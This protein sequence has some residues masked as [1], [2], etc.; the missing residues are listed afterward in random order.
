MPQRALAGAIMSVK[1]GAIT[2]AI[3]AHPENR[4][5]EV[6]RAPETR[7][8]RLTSQTPLNVVCAAYLAHCRTRTTHSSLAPLSAK[9][10]RTYTYSLAPMGWLG[11]VP[12][13]ELRTSQVLERVDELMQ[14]DPGTAGSKPA[15]FA[16]TL[17]ALLAW[18]RARDLCI[19][20]A[21]AQLR[22]EYRPTPRLP[23]TLGQVQRI[24]EEI[25]TYSAVRPSSR[26]LKRDPLYPIAR[27]GVADALRLLILTGARRAEIC[28]ARAEW[29]QLDENQLLVPYAKGHPRV[30]AFGPAA[31]SIF[32]ARLEL[33]QGVTPYLF[34]SMTDANRPLDGTRVLELFHEVCKRVGLYES[35]PTTH[36]RKKYCVHTFRNSLAT[37]ARK[38]GKRIDAIG[39]MLGHRDLKTT[40]RIYTIYAA[41]PEAAEIVNEF[42]AALAG[43][44]R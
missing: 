23:F 42:E 31:R 44:R 21:A 5:S 14:T 4:S 19:H 22:I 9:T 43:V 7:R 38:Q 25:G 30:L 36:L 2:S 34:P 28:R 39:E 35:S 26:N 18:A 41:D 15:R 40:R 6:P 33:T 20:N 11:E 37:W 3:I 24:W 17:R 29:V 32:E 12:V 27:S 10:V 16:Q 13:G 1:S 8:M